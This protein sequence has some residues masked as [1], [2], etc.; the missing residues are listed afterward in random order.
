[1][2][3]HQ[4]LLQGGFFLNQK[5][6]TCTQA[7][8]WIDNMVNQMK[9]LM[10]QSAK[11][12]IVD[13]NQTITGKELHHLIIESIQDYLPRT[14][15]KSGAHK[16]KA[17]LGTILDKFVKLADEPKICDVYE[18]MKGIE[19]TIRKNYENRPQRV[20]DANLLKQL[21]MG[22]RKLQ[23]A[24]CKVLKKRTTEK[25]RIKEWLHIIREGNDSFRNIYDKIW[26]EIILNKE[27]SG[28]ERYRDSIAN[29]RQ[30]IPDLGAK[31]QQTHS[32]P[33]E[34][35]KEAARVKPDF[36]KLIKLEICKRFRLY[37][38]R[39]GSK[40]HI[41]F[42][43]IGERVTRSWPCTVGMCSIMKCDTATTLTSHHM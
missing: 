41:C 13:D 3:C 27:T 30:L 39:S 34:L 2:A 7:C 38:Q 43:C 14:T 36:D 9:D 12:T 31:P 37:A 21:E 32:D 33:V 17:S 5:Q 16:K 42:F 19:E 29:T 22:T 20:P 28:I 24:Y 35:Y 10:H 26:Q 40:V 15:P 4:N 23:D 18:P 1:M 25:G 6:F 11:K 8:Q